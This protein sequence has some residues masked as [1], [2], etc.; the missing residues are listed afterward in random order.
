[1]VAKRRQAQ[2]GGVAPDWVDFSGTHPAT[3]TVTW[4]LDCVQD[5]MTRL[6]HYTPLA[7]S[8]LVVAVAVLG[9]GCATETGG[10]E[11]GEGGRGPRG[12]AGAGR[13]MAR[14][15]RQQPQELWRQYDLNGDGKI[16]PGEFMAVRATCFARYDANG[17][18]RLTRTAVKRFFPPQMA[19]RIDAALSRMDLD[20][21]DVI[22]REEFDRESD[23]LFRQLDTNGDGVIARNELGNVTAAVLG[24]MC[25]E[26]TD[27]LPGAP[28]GNHSGLP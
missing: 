8:L 14:R 25:S 11:R 6:R 16:T 27:R 7:V 15:D 23:R 4:L 28:V 17:D 13:Q 12:R 10:G 3:P 21:D 5:K 22:S 20:R 1:M 2:L 19:D 24:D 26:K 9:T 18:G